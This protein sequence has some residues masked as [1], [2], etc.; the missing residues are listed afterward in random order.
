[1]AKDADNAFSYFSQAAAAGDQQ[2]M[3]RLAAI[4]GT[5][6]LGRTPDPA[7]AKQWQERASRR[8]PLF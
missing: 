4:Y 7:L 2:A 3:L 1:V 5:G 6:E 8:P